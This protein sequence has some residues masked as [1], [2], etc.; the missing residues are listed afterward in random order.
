MYW[1]LVLQSHDEMLKRLEWNL[2]LVLVELVMRQRY[3]A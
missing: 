2:N 3:A 1:L